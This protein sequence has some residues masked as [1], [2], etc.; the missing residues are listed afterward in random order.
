MIPK[1]DGVDGAKFRLQRW[2][3][4]SPGLWPSVDNQ[5]RTT[6]GSC[7]CGVVKNYSIG[8]LKAFV[9]EGVTEDIVTKRYAPVA[10][11]SP[12]S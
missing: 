11:S 9:R 7:K 3:E 8:E 2:S 1:P 6:A 4:T 5:S 12:G 10:L